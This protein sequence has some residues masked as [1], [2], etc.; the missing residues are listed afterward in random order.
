M[1]ELIDM[2]AYDIMTPEIRYV[3]KKTSIKDAAIRMINE[4]IGALI[5]TDN[6]NPIGIVTKRDIIW[7]V[8]FEKRDPEKDTVDKIM[9]S[10]M[11][12]V[13]SDADISIVLDTM[14]RNNITHLPVREGDKIVGIIS[15]YDLIMIL[16]DL[17]DMI[18]SRSL[19][20]KG[21]EE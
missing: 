3:D 4:G 19:R 13:D 18:K 21:S 2:K 8:L 12:T 6:D 10:P 7:G 5:I 11:I 14:I 15:D 20:S 16:R 9:S 17:L 1:E